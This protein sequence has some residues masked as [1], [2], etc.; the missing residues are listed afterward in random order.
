[1]R[2]FRSNA[3]HEGKGFTR[4]KFLKVAGA[5]GACA[6]LAEG[7]WFLRRVASAQEPIRI[8]NITPRTGFLGQEGSYGVLGAKMAVD[9][10]NARGG[11]LGRPIELLMEDSVNPGVANQKATKLIEKNRVHVLTGEISSASALAIS[12]VAQRH[13]VLYFNTGANSDEIR[14]GSCH[15]YSFCVEGSNTMYVS[16]VA[17]WLIR[18]KKINRWYFLTADYAFGHDLYGVSSRFLEEHGGTNLGNDMVPTGT[19]DYSSYI[20][21]I[22]AAKPDMVFSCLAGIDITTFLKQFREFGYPYEV[23]GGASST[24]L[25]W[26]VGIEALSGVWQCMWYHK[27]DKPGVAEFTDRFR[28]RYGKPPENCAWSDYTA[29]NIYLEAVEKTGTTDCKELVE[30]LESGVTFD[31]MKGR[32]ASFRKLDHQLM[33]PM[34]VVRMSNRE[35]MEDE[36]DIFK[37][38][39]EVPR[40]DESLELIQIPAEESRCDMEP[41]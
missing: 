39:E 22:M 34:F 21:K 11:V 16:A 36:W 38:I 32:P 10:A 23:A 19:T 5:A 12:E 20:L 37:V 33:Q 4:R 18:E 35:E 27:L 15:R 14:S 31:I 26:A 8:G 29:I 3:R 7:P 41:L 17:R 28:R 1:M 24:V 13:K 6:L 30:F 2:K 25:F 40:P 9:E